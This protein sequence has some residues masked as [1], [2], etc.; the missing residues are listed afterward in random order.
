MPYMIVFFVVQISTVL[1]FLEYLKRKIQSLKKL[2]GN[3]KKFEIIS[4]F[5]K[6]KELLYDFLLKLRVHKTSFFLTIFLESE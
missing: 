3:K 1:L 5:E 4:K 2:K 6:V